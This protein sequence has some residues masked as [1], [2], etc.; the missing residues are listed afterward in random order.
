VFTAAVVAVVLVV[1]ELLL[2]AVVAVAPPAAVVVVAPLAAVVVVAPFATEVVVT[3]DFFF[4]AE[5]L[6][7][8]QAA[9]RTPRASRPAATCRSRPVRGRLDRP[10]G[11]TPL[12][13][14]CSVTLRSCSS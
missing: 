9:A 4:V 2:A 7:D 3:E 12:A 14:I 13:R 10:E 1:F 5:G 11:D 6:D 8:P